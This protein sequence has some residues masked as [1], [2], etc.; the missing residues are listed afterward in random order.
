VGER[1][2]ALSASSAPSS[3][4]GTH[5]SRPGTTS[6]KKCRAVCDHPRNLTD[7]QLEALAGCGGVLGM[8][9]L[10]FVVDRDAPT[11]SRWLDHFDHPVGVM[12][13][14]TSACEPTSSTRSNPNRSQSRVLRSTALQGRSTSR[15]TVEDLLDDV[16]LRVGV[17]LDVRP[18]ALGQSSLR[19]GIALTV[20]WDRA[21]TIAKQ[22]H[23]LDLE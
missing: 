5:P 21:Q 4:L 3:T 15:R 18:L 9:A 23:A 16:G 8:M 22:Q 12:G 20:P 11:L 1:S 17:V 6:S 19:R 14:E 7:W 2:S 13:F 10:P